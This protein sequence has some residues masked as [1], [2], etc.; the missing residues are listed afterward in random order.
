[1]NIEIGISRNTKCAGDLERFSKIQSHMLPETFV[2][3]L[4]VKV[5]TEMQLILLLEWKYHISSL[6][7]VPIMRHVWDL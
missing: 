3:T 4:S 1:M 6:P 5:V 2:I 7:V